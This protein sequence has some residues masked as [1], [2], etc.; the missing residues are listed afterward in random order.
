MVGFLHGIKPLVEGMSTTGAVLAVS[1][2]ADQR[3]ARP[4]ATAKVNAANRL[5]PAEELKKLKPSSCPPSIVVL[6]RSRAA[7]DAIPSSAEAPRWGK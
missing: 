2:I 7:R 1:P 6:S 4:S 3:H 5:G